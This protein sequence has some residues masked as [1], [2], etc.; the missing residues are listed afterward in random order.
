ISDSPLCRAC[1][2]TDETLGDL[3]GLLSFWR[4]FTIRDP[5]GS[6]INHTYNGHFGLTKYGDSPKKRRRRRRRR[7][8][9]SGR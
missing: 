3:G 7:K 2:E 8:N 5:A 6:R 9:W 1:M 4:E